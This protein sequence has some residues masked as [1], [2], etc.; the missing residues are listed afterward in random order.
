M[1]WSEHIKRLIKQLICE[2]S[3][4]VF[5]LIS[6]AFILYIDWL[7]GKYLSLHF[8]VSK[9]K[10]LFHFETYAFRFA[11]IMAILISNSDE[12]YR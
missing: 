9:S 3:C 6:S 11:V 1:E 7:Q 12:G 2:P 5:I 4:I 8:D 10:I